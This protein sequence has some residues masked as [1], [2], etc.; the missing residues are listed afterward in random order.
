MPL[1]D[2]YPYGV[3]FVGR[4]IAPSIP[5]SVDG[6]AFL[7][8]IPYER[9]QGGHPYVVT[10]RHVVDGVRNTFV[11]VD[12]QPEGAIEDVSIDR[13]YFNPDGHD[14]AV[15]PLNLPDRHNM[16]ATGI[17]EFI[18]SPEIDN[19]D[20]YAKGANIELGSAVYFIGLFLGID[21]MGEGNIPMVR[22]GTLGR[23][24]QE[25]CPVKYHESQ[26]TTYITAHLIDCRSFGGFSG[27]PCYLYQSRAGVIDGQSIG[28]KERIT[29]LGLIGGHYDDWAEVH[30][31]TGK[32]DLRSEVNTGVG[33]VIPVEYIRDTL[34]QKELVVMR[35]ETEKRESVEKGATPDSARSQESEWDRFEALTQRLVESRKQPDGDPTGDAESN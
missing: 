35:K 11:R 2:T 10:A 6:T 3:L 14:V 18:D 9:G 8:G 15:A 1:K 7:V 20:W 32:S 16:T 17:D 29:L 4:W 19:D 13:W 23:L 31:P 25:R 21:A 33:Y 22:S 34:M 24:W 26:P 5:D 27:S 30:H 28:T 12:M